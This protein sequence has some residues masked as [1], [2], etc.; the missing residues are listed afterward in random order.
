M[1]GNCK[2]D[3]LNLGANRYL[4][5]DSLHELQEGKYGLKW[6]LIINNYLFKN[7]QSSGYLLNKHLFMNY[8]ALA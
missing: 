4:K 8:K 7:G 1:V 6:L 5:N 2:L 3:S